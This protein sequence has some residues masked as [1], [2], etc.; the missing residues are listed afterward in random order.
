[1][2]LLLLATS[3]LLLSACQ[4]TAFEVPPVAA[5]PCDVRLVGHWDSIGDTPDENGD[6]QMDISTDCKLELADRKD[7]KLRQG[8]PTQLFVG[9]HGGQQYL[10]VD[11]TWSQRRFDSDLPVHEGDV[12]L[13][14]YRI[15][16]AELE[17]V[18]PDDKAIAHRI[19]DEGIRGEIYKG[20]H[21]LKNRITGGPH[22]ELLASEGFFGK[23]PARFRRGKTQAA[24]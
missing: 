1:M 15:E 19:L 12:Y 8:E 17:V 16:N 7:G 11:S 2:K 6:V 24:P 14:R 21:G 22:P 10:W 3:V 5:T 4:G 23:E 18:S 20:E 13:M 9:Q